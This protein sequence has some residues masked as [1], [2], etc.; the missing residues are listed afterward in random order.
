MRYFT[1]GETVYKTDG[2]CD[3]VVGTFDS[4]SPNLW[5]R[6]TEGLSFSPKSL[7]LIAEAIQA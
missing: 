5:F 3:A 4:A 6:P 2:M 7:I 1:K